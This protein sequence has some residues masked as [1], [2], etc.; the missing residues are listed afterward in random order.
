M[1]YR[2]IKGRQVRAARAMLDLSRKAFASKAGVSL[3][4]LIRLEE[5]VVD[6]RRST[7]IKVISTLE[8]LGIP[9]KNNDDGTFGIKVTGKSDLDQN[10][11]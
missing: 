5:D 1:T 2:M 3:S 10:P 4:S 7:V 9:L 6:V 8:N 11:G